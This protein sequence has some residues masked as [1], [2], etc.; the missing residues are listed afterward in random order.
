M[1]KEISV[2]SFLIIYLLYTA[3]QI[4]KIK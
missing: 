2:H 4:L 1:S 3:L